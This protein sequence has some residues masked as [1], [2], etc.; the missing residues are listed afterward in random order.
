VFQ[1]RDCAPLG[2]I[3]VVATILTLG[4]ILLRII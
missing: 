3:V 4:I 2:L 1:I